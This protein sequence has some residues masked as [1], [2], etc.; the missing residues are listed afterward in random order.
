MTVEL[1]DSMMTVLRQE[2][3]DLGIPVEQHVGN[4]IQDYF[5][6][7]QYEE[8]SSNNPGFLEVAEYCLSK[9]QELYRRLA[10]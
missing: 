8:S 2:A 9:N 10:K 4:I 3:N 1:N 5:R 7:K 6:L